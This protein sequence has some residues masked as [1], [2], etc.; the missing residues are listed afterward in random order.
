MAK[1]LQEFLKESCKNNVLVINSNVALDVY[2]LAPCDCS[3]LIRDS[4]LLLATKEKEQFS[5]STFNSESTCLRK[6]ES[7]LIQ[8]ANHPQTFLAYCKKFAFRLKKERVNHEIVMKLFDCFNNTLIKLKNDDKL[9][10]VRLLKDIAVSYKETMEASDEFP[11]ELF[12]E[13]DSLKNMN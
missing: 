1:S 3:D 4:F 10:H 2:Y 11:H 13:L 7:T 12:S 6:F 5:F 9:P 8:L